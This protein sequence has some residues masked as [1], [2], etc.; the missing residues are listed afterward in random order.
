ML[1]DMMHRKQD[2][3]LSISQY[4]KLILD[5]TL[6]TLFSFPILIYVSFHRGKWREAERDGGLIGPAKEGYT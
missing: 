5:T 3:L 4:H 2:P 1:L 6:F